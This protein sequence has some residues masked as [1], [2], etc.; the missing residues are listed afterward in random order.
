[1]RWPPTESL[2]PRPNA[3]LRMHAAWGGGEGCDR[4]WPL[5]VRSCTPGRRMERSCKVLPGLSL[6]P[7]PPRAAGDHCQLPGDPKHPRPRGLKL[8]SS[9]GPGAAE[10]GLLAGRCLWPKP[11]SS[12]LWPGPGSEHRAVC[13]LWDPAVNTPP[14][15]CSPAARAELGEKGTSWGD[16]DRERSGQR[17]KETAT[18]RPCRTREPEPRQKRPKARLGLR[19]HA[20]QLSPGHRRG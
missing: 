17:E 8:I 12:D 2:C 5:C 9:S 3:D 15:G 13:R 6:T 7:L 18:Q 10:A 11:G 4:S 16:T 1:M 14:Q 19:G 20:G